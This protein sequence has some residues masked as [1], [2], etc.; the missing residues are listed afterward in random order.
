MHHCCRVQVIS[1]KIYEQG[2][3]HMGGIV[4]PACADICKV[5][6]LGLLN[7]YSTMANNYCITLIIVIKSLTLGSLIR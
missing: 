7:K 5:T 3:L 1:I 6:L 2:W 4:C